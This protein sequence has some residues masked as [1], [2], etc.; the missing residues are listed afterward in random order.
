MTTLHEVIETSLS[1]ERTFEFIA[2]FANSQAWDPGVTSSARIGSGPVAVGARYALQVRFRKGTMPMEY[3]V[4]EYAPP[5]RVVLE[6]SGSR[7]DATDTIEF[8]PTATGG[9]RIDYTADLR[10]RGVLRVL[11][12]FLGGTFDGIGKAALAGMRRALDERAAGAG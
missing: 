9:T 10:L 12:P 7:I 4:T 5:S 2:D 11:Q 1:P 3:R 6:G 8:A